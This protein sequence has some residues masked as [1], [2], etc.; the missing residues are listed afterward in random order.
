M[1]VITNREILK[2][3]GLR[4]FGSRPNTDGPNELR[5]LDVKKNAR[6]WSVTEV[7]D[8]LAPAE[9]EALNTEYKLNL[10]PD[11]DWF[12][13]L[14]VACKVMDQARKQKKSILLFVHGYN[15]D[16]ED[17]LAAAHEIQGLHDVIV[18][19]FTWPANGGGAISGTLSYKSD[20]RDA[21]VSTGAFDRVLGKIYALHNL[22]IAARQKELKSQA[23]KKHENNHEKANRLFSELVRKDCAVTLN[24]LCHSMGNYLLKYTLK[25]SETNATNLIFDNINL[26]AADANNEDHRDWVGKMDVR[27]RLNIVINENDS[28]LGVS[29]LKPGDEQK[30]RLGHYTRNLNSVNATYIDV[31]KSDHI[32]D[33]HTYFKGDVA[34]KNKELR[35]LFTQ[36][37]NGKS[38]EGEL[39]YKASNNSYVMEG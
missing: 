25:P 29:R 26:V 24:L 7:N 14:E 8:K 21:R 13:S 36:I 9:V 15:N 11:E 17:V 6:S 39:T 22:L 38:V 30:A 3:K 34:L 2:E 12:G 18:V 37:F 33:E 32:G 16:I 28:A 20:K 31:T 35:E 5:L 10:D 4:A 27:N 23:F 19:P 1:Y